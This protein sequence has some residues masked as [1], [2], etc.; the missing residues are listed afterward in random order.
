LSVQRKIDCGRHW[1]CIALAALC[2]LAA[3]TSSSSGTGSNTN[4]VLCQVDGDCHGNERCVADRCTAP[5]GSNA[6]GGDGAAASLQLV[7][8]DGGPGVCTGEA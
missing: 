2:F 6:E 5:G 4:W 1:A 8:R 3:C 7:G